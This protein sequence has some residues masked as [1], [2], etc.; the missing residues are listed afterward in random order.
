MYK[1]RTDDGEVI[2]VDFATMMTMDAA[3]V[4]TLPGGTTARRIRDG[5]GSFRRQTETVTGG[6]Q[7]EI[8][9]DAMGVPAHA[10]EDYRRNAAEYGFKSVEF[11][12]DP[13]SRHFYQAVF[14]NRAEYR[15]YMK[16]RGLRDQNSINGGAHAV[17]EAEL[18]RLAERLSL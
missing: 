8:V 18:S 12:Q 13:T 7:M 5:Q 9:S 14:K 16:H 11:R 6:V 17:S 4:I 1:F 15:R 2:D 3:G 10:V